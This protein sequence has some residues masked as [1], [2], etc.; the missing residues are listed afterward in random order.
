MKAIDKTNH[1]AETAHGNNKQSY[2][3]MFLV[4]S[5]LDEK[6]TNSVFEQIKETITKHEGS[7]NAARVWAQKRKLCYPIRK[8]LEATYYLVDFKLKPGLVDTIRRAYRLNENILRALVV[9]KQ[10]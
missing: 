6:K 8:Q 1:L 5:G 10:S 2:E 3:G 9:R 4:D 7:I